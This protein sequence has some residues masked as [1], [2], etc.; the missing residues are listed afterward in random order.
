MTRSGTGQA[1]HRRSRGLISRLRVVSLVAGVC[2]TLS[3]TAPAA[4]AA[5]AH[6]QSRSPLRVG[7]VT[8]V[9]AGCSGQ[10]A[11][12]EQATARPDY[13][14]EAWIGCGGEGFARSTDGGAHFQRPITLP[15]SSDSDDPAVAVAPDGTVYVSYL[16]YRN[17]YGYP[18]VATS[19]DH[20][21]TFS[22]VSSLTSHLPKGNWGD[23]DFIAAG[24]DGRV[25]VTWDY[26]PSAADVKIICSPVGS[27]AYDAVDAT[28]VIQTSTDHGKTWGP[29]TAMQP[30]FPAGGGY[31][32]SLVV[33]SNGRL[34]ALIWGHH[35]N[36]VTFAVHPGHEYFTSSTDGGET[37]TPAVEVGAEAGSIA[38][39]TWWIDGDLSIDRAGNLYATWDTQTATSDIGWISYSTDH[40]RRWS[41]PMRVTQDRHN[42]I[43]NVEVV[44][45]GSGVAAV[46]WQSD[47]A[48]RGYATYLRPFSIAKG[49]L[50]ATVRVSH[51]FG[52]KT[53]WPGDTFGL[54][55]LPGRH[56]PLDRQRVI[57]SWGSAV[58]GRPNSEI[59]AASVRLPHALSR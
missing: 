49:W 58:D 32:A 21:A 46:A 34:D 37:W 18:V 25:Y 5:P 31:D 20:G 48:P 7:P 42:T 41:Q 1:I 56:A 11:E 55:L 3:F 36:P 47:S 12:V 39:L 38:L 52:H 50:A 8:E 14:Y 54:S 4:L 2:A 15:H 30:G 33:Q 19:F 23:R 40:G 26:G 43:H 53:V 59:Y 9:S 51:R 6:G 57:L 24:R 10:N 22:Q 16:R 28:A 13:V 45:V 17:G 29:I 35:L 44:G 27:C